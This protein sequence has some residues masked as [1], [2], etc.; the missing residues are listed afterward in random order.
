MVCAAECPSLS[1]NLLL[2][3]FLFTHRIL[4]SLALVTLFLHITD[5]H[6]QFATNFKCSEN[7][8]AP[9]YILDVKNYVNELS[10]YLNQQKNT[11]MDLMGIGV[12]FLNDEELAWG[13]SNRHVTSMNLA[14]NV[15][16][17]ISFCMTLR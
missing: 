13:N 17:E 6:S 9:E 8:Q 2:T 14:L 12:G 11:N 5:S 15:I 4:H 7:K 1:I 16:K 3:F 10:E